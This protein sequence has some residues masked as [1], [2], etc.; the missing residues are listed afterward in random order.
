MSFLIRGPP[1]A[2]EPVAGFEDIPK[3]GQH[4]T[5]ALPQY[6]SVAEVESLIRRK[7]TQVVQS[8]RNP[9]AKLLRVRVHRHMAAV[10]IHTHA[11]SCLGF[12]VCAQV[13]RK[14]HGSRDTLVTRV[15]A[16]VCVRVRTCSASR[17][18]LSAH[19]CLTLAWWWV[20]APTER[21]ATG[22][23]KAGHPTA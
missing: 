19:G 6:T 1:R 23:A 10:D 4:H 11:V 2:F 14:V 7:A 16:W 9:A 17:P 8:T 18:L 12:C 13:F 3:Q 21:A 20:H 22:A 15:R 5:V